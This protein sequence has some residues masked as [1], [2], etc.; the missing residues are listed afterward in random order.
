MI[1]WNLPIDQLPAELAFDD[2]PLLA[3][4]L[5]LRNVKLRQQLQLAEASLRTENSAT[6]KAELEAAR[7]RIQTLEEALRELE[8]RINER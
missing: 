4:E 7:Q 5:V 2:L 3:R 6:L 1:D 8:Q